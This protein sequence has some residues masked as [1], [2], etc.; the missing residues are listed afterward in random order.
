[1]PKSVLY[2]KLYNYWLIKPYLSKTVICCRFTRLSS[3]IVV[4]LIWVFTTGF[5]FFGYNPPEDHSRILDYNN[6]GKPDSHLFVVLTFNQRTQIPSGVIN[7][8]PNGGVTKTLKQWVSVY[9]CDADA[10]KAKKLVELV[11]PDELAEDTVVSLSPRWL[12]NTFFIS[13]RGNKPS[14]RSFL[15][16]PPGS[17]KN[18][19]IYAV[20]LDGTVR[21]VNVI[22]SK[23]K[24][25]V[26]AEQ[27]QDSH[28]KTDDSREYVWV[29]ASWHEVIISTNQ[30]PLENG[31]R[32]N[33]RIFI[34]NK[35]SGELEPVEGCRFVK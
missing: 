19:H 22:P 12:E 27:R 11:V 30:S 14:R 26:A 20:A 28:Y 24:E 33:E 25:H 2:R 29:G 21:E 5:S 6:W 23:A 4:I 8:F 18:E 9:L 34:L 15:Y 32:L 31:R 3:L 10:R 35:K 1:M 17:K 13:I 16:G 7:T